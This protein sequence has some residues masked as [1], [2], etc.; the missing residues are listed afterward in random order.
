MRVVAPIFV[1]GLIVGVAYSDVS[2]GVV[3][4]NHS[5][6]RVPDP[7]TNPTP[8]IR[9]AKKACRVVATTLSLLCKGH[10]HA[11]ALAAA[12]KDTATRE[13]AAFREERDRLASILA[14]R[15]MNSKDPCITSCS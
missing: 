11:R 8:A 5:T 12:A 1:D 6:Q 2:R 10:C 9:C 14:R 4:G 7:S 3:A 15:R 13:A